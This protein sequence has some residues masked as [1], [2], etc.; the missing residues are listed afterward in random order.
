MAACGKHFPGHGYAKE[1]SHEVLPVDERSFASLEKE[2]L[3]VF[4]RLIGQGLD[5]IM[6]GHLPVSYTHLTLPTT[7]YV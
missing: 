2:D 5:A 6:P 7:P 4:A 1:D 3:S